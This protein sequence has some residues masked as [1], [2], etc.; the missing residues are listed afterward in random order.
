LIGWVQNQLGKRGLRVMR[1]PFPLDY[2]MDLVRI[3][4]ERE[5]RR[6]DDGFYILQIGANDGVTDDP[7]AHHIDRY[8]WHGVVVE[9]LAGPF[10]ALQKRYKNNDRIQPRQCAIA[11][12][13][14]EA[15]MYTVA[16]RPNEPDR[17]RLATFSRA[18]LLKHRRSIPNLK[19]RIETQTVPARTLDTLITETGM[20]R[21]DLMQ[22]D[23]EGHDFEILK[24]LLHTAL[25]PPIINFESEHLNH[26]EKR[27]CCE[28]LAAEGY[29]FRSSKGDTTAY[30]DPGPLES[31]SSRDAKH[32]ES[33]VQYK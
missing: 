17:T 31:E 1:L 11:W 28:M 5:M 14:G 18:V 2:E 30:L 26:H 3:L 4:A 9:P 25:R 7:L 23:T 12:Q 8:G 16:P 24:M 13:D 20:P 27:A 15:T 21:I 10:A 22:I 33:T 32:H 29:R 6:R 19:Q